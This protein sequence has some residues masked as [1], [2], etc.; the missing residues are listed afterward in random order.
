YPKV[1]EA[2]F[3]DSEVFAKLRLLNIIPSD[4]SSDAEF[5]RRVTIDAIGTLPTPNEIRVYLADQSPDKRLRKIDALLADP[6]HAALGATRLGDITGNNLDGMEDRREL[7]AK[8]AKMWHDW[9]RK[10]IA[11]NLQYDQIVRG[12]LTATS[13]EG[14]DIQQWVAKEANLNESLRKGFRT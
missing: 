9:F 12:I 6:M 1:P 2:N 8:R 10:R 5:L 3:V 4:L 13:R 14:Q 11:E 7:G